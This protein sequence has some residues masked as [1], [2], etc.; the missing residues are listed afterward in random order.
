MGCFI[1]EVNQNHKNEHLSLRDAIILITVLDNV[2]SDGIA[3]E[4]TVSSY[5]GYGKILG[6]L[7]DDKLQASTDNA[8]RKRRFH[9]YVDDTF[10]CFVNHKREIK[11]DLNQCDSWVGD[12]KLL[13]LVI[14]KFDR[15]GDN[16][17]I[18]SDFFNN[19]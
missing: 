19:I 8:I 3:F 16:N 12:R 6:E 7:F 10:D 1:F 11:I 18:R 9:S 4:I 5:G 14:A 17:L 2:I 13:D 15:Y